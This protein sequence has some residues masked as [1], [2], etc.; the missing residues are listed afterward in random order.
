MPLTK[1]GPF[2]SAFEK[3][4]LRVPGYLELLNL[5]NRQDALVVIE[6]VDRALAAGDPEPWVAAMLA[7]PNWRPHL[8]AAV[9]FLLERSARLDAKL[10][11][12]AADAGSWVIPQLVVAALF[13]DP[14]FARRAR[15]RLDAKCPITTRHWDGV[16]PA[17]LE[18]AVSPRSGK[19]AAALL[20]LCS[21]VPELAGSEEQW[22][23]DP[24][25]LALLA[26]DSSWDNSE[27]ITAAWTSGVCACF[28][29][30]GS[31]LAPAVA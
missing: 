17:Q 18:G 5:P 3:G 6:R 27:E 25:V 19:L 23:A 13:C 16:V 4:E 15:Q 26:E 1:F 21:Y 20:R 10:L 31:V 8:A 30:R 12:D 22:R 9:A 28:A 29:E 7:E 11:W 2:A 24:E 14:L